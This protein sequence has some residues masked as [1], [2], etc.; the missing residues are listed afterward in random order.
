MLAALLTGALTPSAVLGEIRGVDA[1]FL[2]KLDDLKAEFFEGNSRIDVLTAFRVRGIEWLRVRVWVHPKEGYCG[3]PKTLELCKKAKSLGYRLL[4]N[5]HYSDDWADPQKQIPPAAWKDFDLDGMAKAVYAHTRGTLEA[6]DRQGTPA[7]MVQIG[8]EIRD[9]MLWPHGQL[10]KGNWDG[11]ERLLKAGIRGT[12][13]AQLSEQPLISIHHDQGGNAKQCG[14]FYGQLE[15]RGVVYDALQLSY[16]PWWHGTFAQLRENLNT[17]AT[18]FKKPVFVGETAYP[19]TLSWKDRTGNFVGLDRHL[20]PGFPA[21]PVGQAGF[22]TE[23][24]KI[25]METPNRLGAGVIYWAPEYV[26]VPGLPTPYENLAL[27][28][29][30]QKILPG[31]DALGR[32]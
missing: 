32:P 1:S 31:A 14:E 16:Y 30:D 17:L 28:D 19:F 3:V 29:F 12:K 23:L 2:P 25:V 24:R 13:E 22:L 7:D 21:S 18:R 27:F 20:V 8:N 26:A 15:K 11:L 4:I 9:G 10:S 6:L 5:F